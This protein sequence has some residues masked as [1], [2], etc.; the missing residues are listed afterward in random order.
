MYF[1]ILERGIKNY[2]HIYMNSK[3]ETSMESQRLHLD[4]KARNLQLDDAE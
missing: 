3:S 4:P 2:L 1:S